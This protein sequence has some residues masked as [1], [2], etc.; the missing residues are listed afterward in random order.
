MT[1]IISIALAFIT[2]GLFKKQ[3]SSGVDVVTDSFD[4]VIKSIN[5]LGEDNK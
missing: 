2:L 1:D 5:K 4:K 3:A